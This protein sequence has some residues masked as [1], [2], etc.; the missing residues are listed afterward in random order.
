MDITKRES[1]LFNRDRVNVGDVHLDRLSSD[2]IKQ[3]LRDFVADGA[4]RQ[5]VTVNLQFLGMAARNS[6]FRDVLNTADLAIADGAPVVWVSKILGAPIADRVTG[7]DIMDYAA[8]L[9]NQ[10]GHK[11]FF[12]GAAPG[13]AEIAAN[14]LRD[15]YPNINIVGSHGGMYNAEGYGRTDEDERSAVEAIRAANPDF[16]FVGLGA[17]KQDFWIRN[18]L[19]EVNVPVSV[20][21]GGVFDVLAGN[22]GRA[23]EWV[24]GIGLEWVY[25]L[26][27]EPRRLWK[28]YI[29]QDIPTL[30]RV[31]FAASRQRLL[32]NSA[33]Q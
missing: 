26:A 31:G 27:M 16:L 23:P 5:V 4:P 13:I 18:H 12:L 21:V 33:P 14:H 19:H 2:D 30:T 22:L 7:H 10:E 6:E 1:T 9:S 25:R 20:G 11:L 28:R 24:Q 8:Q 17:P 3:R 29:L 15:K 32:A